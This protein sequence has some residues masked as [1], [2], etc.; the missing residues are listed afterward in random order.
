MDYEII[1]Q[2]E[3]NR[4]VNEVFVKILDDL[5]KDEKGNAFVSG[6][7]Y[8]AATDGN[9][10]VNYA[11]FYEQLYSMIFM[12]IPKEGENPIVKLIFVVPRIYKNIKRIKAADK[13]IAFQNEILDKYF[14][15]P[16]G[17]NIKNKILELKETINAYDII[18]DKDLF[19]QIIYNFEDRM[20]KGI[21]KDLI[22]LSKLKEERNKM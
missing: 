5:P 15:K 14:R 3:I 1:D 20:R 10:I 4:R 8:L 18:D 11:K 21:M 16:T 7:Q 2:S 22:K 13:I 12:Y 17:D 9:Q 19:D 6:K